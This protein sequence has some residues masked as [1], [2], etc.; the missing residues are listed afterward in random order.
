MKLLYECWNKKEKV[1]PHR[2]QAAQAGNSSFLL[3]LFGDPYDEKQ[4]V[5]SFHFDPK[6]LLFS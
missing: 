1:V 5:Q 4:S 6:N 3:L 2:F